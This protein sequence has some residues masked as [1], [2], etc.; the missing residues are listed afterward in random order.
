MALF[1]DICYLGDIEIT[2]NAYG[3]SVERVI[4][5]TNYTFINKKSVT[6]K[7]FYEAQAS[8]YKPELLVIMSLHEYSGQEYLKIDGAEYKVI[9]SYTRGLDMIE[10]TLERGIKS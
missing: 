10:L 5:S 3:D 2:E 4:Y 6:R 1:K 7:E 9:R 8:G